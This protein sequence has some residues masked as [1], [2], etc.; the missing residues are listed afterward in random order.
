MTLRPIAG[1]PGDAP[2][3]D[4]PSGQPGSIG[5]FAPR[6]RGG[7]SAAFS[8]PP[9]VEPGTAA[10]PRRP[11]PGPVEIRGDDGIALV[12]RVFPEV[13]A[14]CRASMTVSLAGETTGLF[15]RRGPLLDLTGEEAKAFLRA[16]RDG[17][18]PATF[19]DSRSGFQVEFLAGQEGPVFIVGKAGDAN[20]RRRFSVPVDVVAEMVTSLLDDLGP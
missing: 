15:A 9:P 12:Y 14:I 4:F 20:S 1:A 19:A 16:V 18:A 10:P 13:P 2:I 6:R 7:T 8:L 17:E 5:E 3:P 11:E